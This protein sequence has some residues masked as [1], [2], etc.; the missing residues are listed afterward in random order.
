MFLTLKALLHKRGTNSAILAIALLV[1]ILA[2]MTSVVNHVNSQTEAIS[3]TRDIGET[4][5]IISKNSTNISDS[6]VN[7]Q[8]AS[9]LSDR[10]AIKYVLPQKVFKATLLVNSESYAVLVRGVNTSEFFTTRHAYVNGSIADEMQVNVGEI[11]ARLVSINN[12]DE[13]DIT[14]NDKVI[15]VETAGIIQTFTQSDTELI[16]SMSIADLLVDH[17]DKVSV[18]EFAI[19]NGNDEEILYISELL[20]TNVKIVKV[21]QT[22]AFVQDVNSQTLSFL[23]IWSL[24]VYT[25]VAVASYVI[26]T[27]L[28]VESSYELAMLRALG[29]KRIIVFKSVIIV[30]VAITLLGFI[31]GLAI[32][33]AG[34]QVL[35]TIM[36][37]TWKDIS[38]TPF[39]NIKQATQIAL[40]TA[41]SSIL[42]CMY[43]AMKAMRKNYAELTL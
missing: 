10:D 3:R 15:K 25:T 43:P 5:F 2:S 11:L 8:I 24:A 33:V 14:I 17:S 1:A 38:I 34:T 13:I 12:G 42:G 19:E 40:F 29:A 16:V 21:Q 39:L 4:F 23:N 31:L 18:I 7:I 37:L 22:K 6:Q 35:A 36:R 27:C 9:L 20:P 32:G 28:A 41:T 26:A 30:T